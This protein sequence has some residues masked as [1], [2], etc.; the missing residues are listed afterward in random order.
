VNEIRD[1]DDRSHYA[2]YYDRR[3]QVLEMEEYEEMLEALGRSNVHGRDDIREFCFDYIDTIRQH[4][5]A[6]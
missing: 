2:P 5:R 6:A 4:R 3:E 1:L